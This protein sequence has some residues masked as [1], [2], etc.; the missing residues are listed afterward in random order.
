MHGVYSNT[1]GPQDSER[2]ETSFISMVCA[3]DSV[4]IVA[5]Q[6]FTHVT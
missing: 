5:W 2:A 6:Q 1:N 3:L 4:E